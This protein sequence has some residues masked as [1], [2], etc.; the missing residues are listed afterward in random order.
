MVFQWDS[1]LCWVG[2]GR[3]HRTVRPISD[4]GLIEEC[5]VEDR[6]GS[7]GCGIGKHNKVGITMGLRRRK[8][9][10]IKLGTIIEIGRLHIHMNH[11]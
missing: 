6:Q 2:R 11:F 10:G 9:R 8:N 3:G 7:D 1:R 5:E 4:D